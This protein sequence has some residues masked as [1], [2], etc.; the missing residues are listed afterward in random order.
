VLGAPQ[1]IATVDHRLSLSLGIGIGDDDAGDVQ[2]RNAMAASGMVFDLQ[3]LPA[4]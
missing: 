1:G 2:A 3:D 4:Q